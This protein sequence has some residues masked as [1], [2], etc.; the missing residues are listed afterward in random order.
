MRVLRNVLLGAL[1]VATATACDDDPLKTKAPGE[2]APPTQGVQA[3]LAVDRQDAKPGDVVEIA[4]KLQIGT[5]SNVKL[6][7]YTGRLTFD[8][9]ALAYVDEIKI[10]DGMRVANPNAAEQGTIRF[11]GAAAKGFADLILYRAHFEVRKADFEE[12]LRFQIE[13]LSSAVALG[14]LESQMK[15]APTVFYSRTGN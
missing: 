5:A 6:G 10:N 15:V 13:E 2:P 7:S 3:Y 4:V 11:A 9:E 8:P 1:V 14:H 12:A